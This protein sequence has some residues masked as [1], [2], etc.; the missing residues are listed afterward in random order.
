MSTG[1][2]QLEAMKE[3]LKATTQ[4]KN[5]AVKENDV[6][7]DKEKE[8]APSSSMVIENGVST[9]DN[10]EQVPKLSLFQLKKN[11]ILKEFISGLRKFSGMS[12]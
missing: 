1:F 10:Q 2:Q 8:I 3:L 7:V 5:S 6:H 12:E 11:K 4:N 9:K